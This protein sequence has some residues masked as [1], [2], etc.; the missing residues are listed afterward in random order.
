MIRAELE[1][2]IL[3]KERE[4]LK[5]IKNKYGLELYEELEDIEKELKLEFPKYYEGI[6]DDLW[7]LKALM[8]N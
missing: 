7:H 1:I 2:K 3:R 4:L 8:E 6:L 5:K